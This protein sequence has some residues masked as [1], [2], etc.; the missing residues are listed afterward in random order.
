[1][2]PEQWERIFKLCADT[3]DQSVS[4][5]TK[6]LDEVCAGNELLRQEIV[7]LLAYEGQAEGFMETPPGD[8]VAA[9][10]VERQNLLQ[11]ELKMKYYCPKCGY[12]PDNQAQTACPA[13]NVPLLRD[14][15]NLVGQVLDNKYCIEVPVGEGGFGIVYRAKHVIL[16]R[17]E[18]LKILR[19]DLAHEGPKVI[20]LFKKEGEITSQLE[21]DNIA[22]VHDAGC[23]RGF[24][25]IAMQWLE[26]Y[27]LADELATSGQLSFERIANILHQ[28]VFALE[29]AHAKGIVHRDLKP[30][31]IFLIK[32][33]DQLEQVKVIDFGIAKVLSNAEASKNSIVAGTPLYASPEQLQSE[34]IID[35]RADI[36]SLGIILYEMLTGKLPFNADPEDERMPPK[37][38]RSPQPLH[39]ILTDVPSALEKLVKSMLAKKPNQRPSSASEISIRFDK[40]LE[41]WKRAKAVTVASQA[42]ISPKRAF[43]WYLVITAGVLLF[44]GALIMFPRIPEILEVPRKT[45]P[46][47][48]SPMSFSKPV[49]DTMIASSPVALTIPSPA[50]KPPLSD[51]QRVTKLL[52][53]IKELEKT[54]VK[55]KEQEALRLCK[56]ALKIDPGNPEIKKIR[57]RIKKTLE[58]GNRNR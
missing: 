21:H 12:Q 50:P 36:Y 24:F 39:E 20:E 15:Y 32:K 30:S 48:A 16:G 7:S 46:P 4:R 52:S 23:D 37:P 34:E 9:A 35:R 29:E 11:R 22:Q 49:S 58:T 6:F 25:Y 57:E 40:V 18:A 56:D 44:I 27:T 1:M 45:P 41:N 3:L 28:I 43:A 38:R 55:A 8:V 26:G 51:R 54:G 17:R 33:E 53:D 47:L 10:L 42:P 19:P 31:N 14:T 13:H 5:R 2:K